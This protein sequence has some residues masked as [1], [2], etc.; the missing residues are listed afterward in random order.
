MRNSGRKLAIA[1]SVAVA[2]GGFAAA[3]PAA[4]GPATSADQ[5]RVQV[6]SYTAASGVTPPAA[7]TGPKG[8]KPTAWGVATYPSDLKGSVELKAGPGGGTWT[9][10]TTVDG[11]YKGCYSNYNHSSK[12]HSASVAI[13]NGTDKDTR[14]AGTWA[15]AYAK[16][17]FAHTCY[18]YWATY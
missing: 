13:A 14:S 4:A 5:S 15:K 16:A 11:L 17:G 2:I 6:Q 10:G 7:L 12:K 9:H 3:G 1:A 18:A 8:E